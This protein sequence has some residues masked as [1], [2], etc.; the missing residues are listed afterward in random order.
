MLK[1]TQVHMSAQQS[2]NP[3]N[4]YRR[5]RLPCGECRVGE[6]LNSSHSKEISQVASSDLV[7]EAPKASK[8]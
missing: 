5:L 7:Q 2:H 4:E 6:L 1:H 8:L 3:K